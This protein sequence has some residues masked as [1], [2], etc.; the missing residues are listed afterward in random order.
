MSCYTERDAAAAIAPWRTFA[1]WAICRDAVAWMRSCRQ[2][3][4]ERQR[5]LDYMAFDHRAAADIGIKRCDS[6]EWASRP[7]WR[8]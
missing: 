5:L 2:R 1:W 3:Q 8:D 4:R 6:L 7:F